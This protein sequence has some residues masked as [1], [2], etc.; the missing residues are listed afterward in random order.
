MV[1]SPVWFAGKW[2]GQGLVVH[3]QIPYKEMLEFKVL[4]TEPCTMV[5]VQSFT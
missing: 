3:K 4:R 5:C 1:E 2:Q